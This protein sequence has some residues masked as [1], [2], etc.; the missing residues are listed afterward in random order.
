MAITVYAITIY[1]TRIS[2][3]TISA[4][5]IFLAEIPEVLSCMPSLLDLDL[6]YNALRVVK[7]HSKAMTHLQ[8]L[9]L[10]N[11]RIRVCLPFTSLMV[12]VVPKLK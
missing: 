1:A 2:A 4:P 8:E 7:P 11:N 5:T 3:I 12:L 9:K 6:S 10:N